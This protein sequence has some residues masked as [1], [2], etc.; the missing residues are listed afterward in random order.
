MGPLTMT[1]A[2]ASFQTWQQAGA[3]TSNPYSYLI[4]DGNA[5]E[6]GTGVYSLVGGVE[7]LSRSLLQSSSGGLLNLSG[8]ATVACVAMVSDYATGGGGGGIIST[9]EAGNFLTSAA[10]NCYFL[11]TSAGAYTVTLNPAPAVNELVEVWDSTGHAGANPISFN[12]NGNNIAG[13]ATLANFI[14]I[15]F[16]HARLIFDGFQWLMQ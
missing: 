14:A 5:W 6:L 15:N 8:S 10:F 16:G 2:V 7:S 3:V 11:D 13:S 9:N 1:G 4:Q 12:G